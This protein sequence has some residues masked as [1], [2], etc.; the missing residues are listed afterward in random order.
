MSARLALNE[1]RAAVSQAVAGDGVVVG[2]S[3]AAPG[4]ARTRTRPARPP[5]WLTLP[6]AA[7][8]AAML[9]PLVYLAV[10]ASEAG[11]ETLQIVT[12]AATLRVLGNS[13]L[14]AGLVTVAS[15]ALAV[16]LAW[17]T[18]R[19]DLPGRRAWGVLAVLPLCIPTFVG[20]FTFVSAFGPR[21]MLRSLLAP[22]GVE[23]LP[24]I[25]GL[26]GAVLVLTLFSYP[27][28]LLT[29]RG[30]LLGLDP[31]LEEA[32]RSCGVGR[33]ATFLR[34]TLPQLRPA[35]TAGGL[36]VALY[37]LSDF[38]AVSL[39]RYDSFTRAIYVQYR[40]AFDRTPAAV[41]ALVLV[42]FTLV[43]LL[44]EARAR[45]RRASAY[46]RMGSAPR[47][48]AP[49]P[50]GRWR[51][52]ALAFCS[53][54]VGVALVVPAGV[55]GYWLWR[56]LA[57]GEEF[58]PVARAAGNSLLASGVAAAVAALLAIPVAVLSVRHRGRLTT[59]LERGAY[60]GYALPGIVV[61][62]ALVF[63]GA[64]IGE[65]LYQSL[66]L[67]VFA[68]VVR[69]LPQSVGATRASLLQVPP[70]LEEASRGL[71]RSAFATLATVT[72]PLVRPGILAGAGLV[73]L[74]AMKELP[75]TLLLAPTGYRTLATAVWSAS[76]EAFFARAAAAGLPL[77]LLSGVPLALLALR[78]DGLGGGA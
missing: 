31:A 19:S 41:L 23:R 69:F 40:S 53:T 26:H 10:R 32:S 9:L 43:L 47:A 64:R 59:V 21:G 36:L 5:F 24:E 60:V 1:S 42:A 4:V 67:L 78:R 65:P 22:F 51:V 58:R 18:V 74:T 29:V 75:V 68:Y 48:A 70:S 50:L 62:L 52:P 17:L 77:V 56:G 7:T 35:I 2:P 45:G 38:G 15:A 12:A 76:S 3:A 63:F 28:L 54:V 72:A 20:G 49:V 16:P 30:A 55:L 8:A 34:V 57:T 27:Y 61:A 37:A 25:Y 46:Q 73:F 11:A 14:L 13:A 66:A 71:G 44:V 39:L 33:G 6:A